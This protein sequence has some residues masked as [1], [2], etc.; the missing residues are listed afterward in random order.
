MKQL[1]QLHN[2]DLNL[3]LEQIATKI[4]NQD[5]SNMDWDGLL[6]EIEDMTA[7]QK[8]ALRSYTKRL[9]EHILKLKYWNREKEYNQK[10]WRREVVNFRNEIKE[11]LEDSPSLKNYLQKNYATWYKKSVNAMQQ[12]F[13]IPD[14]NFVLLETIMTENY[15]P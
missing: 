3:W 5:F 7:S 11:I 2:E 12:E 6:E 1:K 4:K 15:F 14:H 8:R 13:E 10:G 9:I